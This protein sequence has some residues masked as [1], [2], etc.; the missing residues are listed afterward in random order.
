M[1]RRRSGELTK[2]ELFAFASIKS[3]LAGGDGEFYSA[4]L[5]EQMELDGRPLPIASLYRALEHL[6]GVGY[7]TSRLESEALAAAEGR[8]PRRL[9]RLTANGRRASVE[10]EVVTE[11]RPR[12]VLAFRAWGA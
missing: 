8:A 9:Y 1:P 7:L 4:L 6:Q 11:E 2:N 3:L 12:L 10:I 5:D